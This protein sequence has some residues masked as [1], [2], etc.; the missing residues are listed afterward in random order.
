MR[1]SELLFFEVVVMKDFQQK[2]LYS[3][4]FFG[5]VCVFPAFAQP[6][7]KIDMLLEIDK[8]LQNPT[9]KQD[10]IQAGRERALLCKSCHGVDGNSAK[11]D[12]PNLAGQN[13]GYLLDQINQFADGSRKDYVMSQL[14]G[15]FSS[16]D[17]V[18]IAIFY[19]SMPVK[20]QRVDREMALKG[21]SL[22]KNKCSGCHGEQGL[23]RQNLARLAGQKALYVK[24]ALTSFRNMANKLVSRSEARRTSPA[25]E[26]IAKTLT[27]EQIQE[28]AA[29]VA[30]LGK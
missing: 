27:D 8:R 10:A 20:P 30:Q 1:D 12:V 16:E 3:L 13:A 4:F 24:N 25:M 22:Y 19:N 11:P 28:L 7:S 9:S 2:M 23:G 17:K 21:G 15:N 14:A 26:G 18:N 29:Y 5:W 6:L